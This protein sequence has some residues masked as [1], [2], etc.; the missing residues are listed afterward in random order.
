MEQIQ[1]V[2]ID[3]IPNVQIVPSNQSEEDVLFDSV[4]AMIDAAIGKDTQSSNNDGGNSSLIT[5]KRTR[6]KGRRLGESSSS[7]HTNSEF[8]AV[9][10]DE[11][12]APS[13]S[14]GDIPVSFPLVPVPAPSSSTAGSVVVSTA[15]FSSFGS[16]ILVFLSGVSTVPLFSSFPTL[17]GSSNL[18]ATS[19]GLSSSTVHPAF[20]T[21][22]LGT[23][24]SSVCPQLKTHVMLTSSSKSSRKSRPKIASNLRPPCLVAS[25]PPVCTSAPHTQETSVRSDKPSFQVYVRGKLEEVHQEMQR[26][27]K[28]INEILEA[29]KKQ[30]KE[31]DEQKRINAENDKKIKVLAIQ[32][33]RQTIQSK[34]LIKRDMAYTSRHETLSATTERLRRIVAELVELLAAQGRIRPCKFKPSASWT[35]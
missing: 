25:R 22:S 28:V 14:S 18:F 21:L 24:S 1:D 34:I 15:G 26:Q 20:M 16:G 29:N 23:S 2:I 8:V 6:Y 19:V 32:Y 30:Q 13:V 12:S 35:S 5:Y 3:D 17:T 7:A 10:A 9:S 11:V 27:T 4:L 33:H 31:L